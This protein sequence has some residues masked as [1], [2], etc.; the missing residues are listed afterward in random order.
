MRSSPGLWLAQ[1]PIGKS[2]EVEG[3]AVADP[4]PDLA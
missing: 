2:D 1:W 4:F 3:G